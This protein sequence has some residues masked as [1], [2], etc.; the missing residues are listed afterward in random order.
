MFYSGTFARALETSNA[1]I[2]AFAVTALADSGNLTTAQATALTQYKSDSVKAEAYRYLIAQGIELDPQDVALNLPD[3]RLGRWMSRNLVAQPGPAFDTERTLLDFY[4]RFGT[5]ELIEMASWSNWPGRTAYRA[6]AI[7]HFAT[8]GDKIREDIRTGFAE[9]AASY[10]NQEVIHWREIESDRAARSA[11]ATPTFSL[12]GGLSSRLER[13]P[14]ELAESSV[15]TR[16]TEY[17]TAALAGIARN[18]REDD[19]QFGRE[20][21]FT[22]DIDL[23]IEAVRVV[24]QFGNAD[25]VDNLTKVAT[26]TDGLLQELAAKGALKLAS[27]PLTVAVGFL[28]TGDEI[29]VSLSVAEIIKHDDIEASSEFLKPY[30]YDQRDAIRKR[31]MLFFTTVLGGD[32]LQDLLTSYTQGETYYYDVVCCFDRHLYSPPRFATAYV[33][34]LKE[35]F[36]GLLEESEGQRGE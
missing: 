9:E 24:N 21:L 30:L 20:Y 17:L 10:F 26:T 7:E 31:V 12:F 35:L 16:R 4:R 5:E 3:D 29:L 28:Q 19:V 6:L 15:D 25:D 2:R 33:N 13:K 22:S 32:A 1:E 8:F 23:R 14:E 36:F 34:Q 27:D 11:G 18:G